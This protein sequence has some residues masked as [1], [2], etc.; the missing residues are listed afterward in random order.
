MKDFIIRIILSCVLFTIPLIPLFII[1]PTHEGTD[2]H[3]YSFINE[4]YIKL[5]ISLFGAAWYYV[6]SKIVDFFLDDVHYE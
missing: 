1:E 4:T 6:A 5:I 3:T 2:L